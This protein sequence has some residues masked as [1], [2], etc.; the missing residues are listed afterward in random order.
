MVNYEACFV[1]FAQKQV[2]FMMFRDVLLHAY[3]CILQLMMLLYIYS[4]L[5]LHSSNTDELKSWLLLVWQ[6]MSIYCFLVIGLLDIARKTYTEIVDD[7]S[8]N[9]LAGILITSP[10]PMHCLTI[11][12]VEFHCIKQIIP[13]SVNGTLIN[14]SNMLSPDLV[15]QMSGTYNLP[16]KVAYSSARGFHIQMY[17]GGAE[18][19][20]QDSLP[21]IFIKVAKC[22][23]T[24]SFTTSDMVSGG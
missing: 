23:N 17:A 22:K 7:L 10:N 16:L 14:A 13:F 6:S 1:F 11:T 2:L 20:T 12:N 21:G 19:Q 5:A 18:A 9:I 24:L 3:A 8:G 15:Q 4:L